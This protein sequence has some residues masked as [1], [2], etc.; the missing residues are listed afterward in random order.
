MKENKNNKNKGKGLRQVERFVMNGNAKPL[1]LT[2]VKSRH[3]TAILQLEVMRKFALANPLVV[4][5]GFDLNVDHSQREPHPTD[6]NILNCPLRDNFCLLVGVKVLDNLGELFWVIDGVVGN[7]KA[8]KTLETSKY[9][10]S[11]WFAMRRYL[12]LALGMDS[13]AVLEQKC[14]VGLISQKDEEIQPLFVR[15]IVPVVTG[16]RDN[17]RATD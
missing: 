2:Y 16:E 4:K 14:K 15:W 6:K 5:D 9:T 17:G 11:L 1:H 7:I 12:H 10:K 8:N 13:D 3:E